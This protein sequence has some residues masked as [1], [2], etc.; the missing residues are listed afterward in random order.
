MLKRYRSNVKE[1]RAAFER[2]QAI[3]R[4]LPDRPAELLARKIE[5]EVTAG[6]EE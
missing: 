2:L 3:V 4:V 5:G 6:L 1:M